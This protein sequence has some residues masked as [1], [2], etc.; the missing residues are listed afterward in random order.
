LIDIT[1]YSIITAII[2]TSI[3]IIIFLIISSRNWILYRINTKLLIIVAVIINIRLLIP[4]ELLFLSEPINSFN[5]LKK[6][7]TFIKQNIISNGVD[8]SNIHFTI[9]GFICLIWFTGF[10]ISQFCYWYPYFTFRKRIRYIN[11]TNDERILKYIEEIK[12]NNNLIFNVKVILNNSIK[13]PAESGYLSKVILLNDYNYSDSEMYYIIFHELSHYA[14]KSHWIK[15]F[16]YFINS[17]FW[18]NPIIRIFRNR[19]DYLLELYVDSYV[20]RNLNRNLKSDYLD[21]ILKVYKSTIICNNNLN[22]YV[23]TLVDVSEEKLIKKRFNFICKHK[24]TNLI[25]ST[26]FLII[27]IL[28]V[29]ISFKYVVQPAFSPPAEECIIPAYDQ[30]NSY[31]IKDGETYTLYINDKLYIY[32]DDINKLQINK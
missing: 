21:C 31:I 22:N 11:P 16:I 18:W 17:V 23:N 14:I 3:F 20:T 28:Y 12:K 15:L 19:M 7:D 29:F 9:L 24:K 26:L 1:P 5:V 30:N 32:T 6:F 8:N 4:I 27:L 13:F 2:T 25:I 10:V